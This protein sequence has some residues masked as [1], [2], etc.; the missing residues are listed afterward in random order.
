MWTTVTALIVGFALVFGGTG[1]SAYAAQES[2]PDEPL[3]G[4][5]LASEELRY[6][7]T[8]QTQNKL[9]LA[10]EFAN[11]RLEE[12]GELGTPASEQAANRYEFHLEQAIQNSAGLPEE[13][14][15]PALGMIQLQLQQ[16][17]QIITRLHEQHPDDAVLQG[18]QLRL[19]ERLE[20]ILS[21]MDDPLKFQEQVRTRTS[22]M[23]QQQLQNQ[24]QNSE[25]GGTPAGAGLPNPS[26]SPNAAGP[27]GTPAPG[28]FGPNGP[29]GTPQPEGETGS[30]TG[31][32][33]STGP[34]DN[35]G[36]NDAGGGGDT[37]GG[38]DT[39]GGG[40]PGGGSDN[41]GGGD[42]GGGSDTGGNG[43]GGSDTGGNGTGGSDTGSN[44]TGGT[45]ESGGTGGSSNSGG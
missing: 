3:Y 24:Q 20:L 27:N 9:S 16:Q 28:G 32:N 25:P 43:T 39:G 21:G 14:I 26:V 37:G 2:L 13:Q 45:G 18:L 42:P 40:D 44:G 15:L 11:R 4:I 38:S 10:L 29:N 17:E 33:N 12:L 1:L 7:L 41:G 30:G 34:Q 22:S 6:I 31:L 8:I 19:R 35:G 36:G 5:K 23:N